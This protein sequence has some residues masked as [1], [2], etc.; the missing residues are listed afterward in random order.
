MNQRRTAQ[1]YAGL[2]PADTRRAALEGDTVMAQFANQTN[3]TRFVNIIVDASSATPTLTFLGDCDDKGGVAVIM[4]APTEIW[5]LVWT[6]NIPVQN[7]PIQP[8]ALSALTWPLPDGQPSF[9]ISAGTNGVLPEAQTN[10]QWILV[11]NYLDKDESGR[12]SYH[13]EILYNNQVFKFD[14]TIVN[15]DPP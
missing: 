6:T 8:A 7:P 3:L 1:Q 13:L 10:P 11:D 15:V 5:L 12:I 2:R 9:V 4:G 14:P